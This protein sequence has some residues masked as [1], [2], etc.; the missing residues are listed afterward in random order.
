MVPPV[1]WRMKNQERRRERRKMQDS[2]HGKDSKCFQWRLLKD[3]KVTHGR[4]NLKHLLGPE[5]TNCLVTVPIK[6][7]FCCY[8]DFFSPLLYF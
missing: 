8:P 6:Q 3:S 5:S 7:S 4:D 2:C 1:G